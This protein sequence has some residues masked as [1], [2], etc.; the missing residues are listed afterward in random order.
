MLGYCGYDRGVENRDLECVIAKK[1]VTSKQEDEEKVEEAIE[2]AC[3]ALRYNGG[4]GGGG[5][6]SQQSWINFHLFAVF[7][8]S[9]LVSRSWAS[10]LS[11]EYRRTCVWRSTSSP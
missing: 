11:S 1:K 10:Y 7:L 5:W 9:Q 3:I 8:R 6:W 4:G 2:D